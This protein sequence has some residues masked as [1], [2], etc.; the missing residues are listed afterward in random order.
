[1]SWLQFHPLTNYEF[2][3][4]EGLF[5][6]NYLVKT[7]T[8]KYVTGSLLLILTVQTIKDFVSLRYLDILDTF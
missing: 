1:M 8:L 5:S 2:L 3:L 4:T 6:L 7:L